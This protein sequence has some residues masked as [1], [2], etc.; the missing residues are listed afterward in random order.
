MVRENGNVTVYGAADCKDTTR[1]RAHLDEL[2]VDYSYVEVNDDDG[3]E[4]LVREWNDGKRRTPTLVLASARGDDRLS[5]PSDTEL[6]GTLGRLGLLPQA[7]R[8]DG[9]PG[10]D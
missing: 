6:D 1:T 5:V 3:A 10:L 7:R 4:R 2:G 8:G 9:S